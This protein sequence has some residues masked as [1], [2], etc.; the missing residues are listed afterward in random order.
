M[1]KHIASD[2]VRQEPFSTYAAAIGDRRLPLKED[3]EQL[4]WLAA[5]ANTKP[6][7]RLRSVK[8]MTQE[9]LR[10]RHLLHITYFKDVKAQTMSAAVVT[11]EHL[12]DLIL[13]TNAD[14]KGRSL[15]DAKLTLP[16]FKLA[17]FGNKRSV[18]GNSW[19]HDDNVLLVSGIELDYDDE[20][21]SFD[22]AV[23][24]IKKAGLRALL[25]TSPRHTDGKPRWR[26]LLPTSTSLSRDRHK[27]LVEWVSGLFGLTFDAASYKLSQTYFY[28]SIDHNPDHRAVV[29]EGRFVDQCAPVTEAAP[30]KRRK[31]P[32]GT[33]TQVDPFKDAYLE[34]DMVRR[35]LEALPNTADID[36]AEWINIL[37]EAHE[38][39]GGSDEGLAVVIAWTLTWAGW[40]L[41]ENRDKRAR[42]AEYTT[43]TWK[44]LRP[45]SKTRASLYRRADQASGTGGAQRLSR[46]RRANPN[47]CALN[48]KGGGK[49]QGVATDCRPRNTV[50]GNGDSGWEGLPLR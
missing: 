12:R 24:I 39:T 5:N 17:T 33:S 19:R 32:Q 47:G 10:E 36:R 18:R 27:G 2:A 34:P 13:S 44:T 26:V 43:E 16:L 49:Q 15:D 3:I 23:E 37:Q 45:H 6:H 8:E 46:Q 21:M 14:T 35:A 4:R 41:P 22:A 42:C 40:A 29:V 11:L 30:D 48:K 20:E 9:E 7:W 38:G 50:V 25:Y 28:G 31:P 1:T